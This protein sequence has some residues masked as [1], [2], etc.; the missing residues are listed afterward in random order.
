MSLNFFTMYKKDLKDLD[1]D[2]S[3]NRKIMQNENK[4]QALFNISKKKKGSHSIDQ[5]GINKEKNKIIKKNN[6]TNKKQP[7]NFNTYYYN[8]FNNNDNN[9]DDDNDNEHEMKKKFKSVLF[10]KYND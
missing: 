9:N 8:Q 2:A 6:N 10:S 4:L 7:R 1:I 3:L 5:K